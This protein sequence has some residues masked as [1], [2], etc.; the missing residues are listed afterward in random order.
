MK[1][2]EKPM[3]AAH[4]FVLLLLL[5]ITPAGMGEETQDDI[6]PAQ[7][8]NLLVIYM[9]AGDL[10]TE[11]Q[12]ATMNIAEILDG[13]GK[14]SE[15]NLQ[16]VLGYG[17]SKTP[18]FGGITYV[19][20]K[21][22]MED[23]SDGVIGNTEDVL[24]HDPDAD[25]GDK[26]T[27]EHFL[28][29]IGENFPSDRKILVFWDHGGGY[30]GFGV[31]E[32][33]DGQL[34][35]TDISQALEASG[36]TYDLIGYDACLMGALEVAKAMEPYG[37]LLI[38]SEETEPGTGWEYETWIKALGE[39]PE[40]GFEDLGRIIVDAYMTR[41]DTGKTLSVIDL[42]KISALIQALDRLGTSMMPY[43]ESIEG[44]RVVG[45][46]YQVPARYG[47]DN[48]EGGETSVDLKS[49]L[50]AI[51]NQTPD[52][53]DEIAV[54]TT[55]I[56][57]TVLY[58]RNDE[59]V[60]ESGGL[61]IMSP[62]RI[63]PDLYEELGDDA[64]I[65]PGWDSFFVNLLEISG[66]DT[67]KP[68]IMRSDSGFLIED[69][70]NTASV[71][72]EY[73]YADG[74]ELI[75]LGNE[76]LDPDENGEYTLPEWDGRWYYLQDMN[77][78]DNYALLGMNFECIVPSGS[79]LYTSEID[80]IRES[81]NTTAV[82]NVYINPQTGETR[83]VACPY[84]IRPNGIIQFSRQNLDLEPNDTMYSYAWKVD[85]DTETGGEWV[86]IGALD[87]SGNTK[88]IYDILPDGTYAQALYAE[89][90]NKPGDYAG[91]QVFQIENG[92]ITLVE[93]ETNITALQE[94]EENNQ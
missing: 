90:G 57:E 67:E 91:M 45:K 51:G 28:S 38:G 9:I 22:L 30:D 41:D 84:T 59:Y 72:A 19:T 44:Y 87:I 61:S 5:W 39:N 66:Q 75:L 93:S 4:I 65:T 17:G 48:R 74:D 73:Y 63:T 52:L 83:L 71:Y 40:I 36:S 8:H 62:S 60:P 58:H 76:P 43:T 25:M 86:E 35:L 46:A 14:T 24:Y 20:V 70:T 68:E 81:L 92:E 64:R 78:E 53:A 47:S 12:S 82:L 77:N 2:T 49:F 32:V 89:Y 79:V 15:Q 55:R 34:S 31:D 85:E 1:I 18:G 94:P 16:I 21:E 23:A 13:Y 7:T 26:K 54:V 56:D 80:L 33:T 88:L 6:S 3:R 29:W 42:T 11:T 37:I 10:E 50:K 69:P 27:L